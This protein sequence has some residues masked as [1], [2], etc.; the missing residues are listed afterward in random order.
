M[1][2]LL[3]ATALRCWRCSSDNTNGEFCR[4]PFNVTLMSDVQRKWAYVDCV[5]PVGQIQPHQ[6]SKARSVC[7][8]MVQQGV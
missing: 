8:K 4:D 1:F 7:K 5:L 2:S 6:L 3:S